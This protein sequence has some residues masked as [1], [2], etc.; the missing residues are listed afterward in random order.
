MDSHFTVQLSTFIFYFL[1]EILFFFFFQNHVRKSNNNFT[2]ELCPFALNSSKKN[3]WDETDK[4]L[5]LLFSGIILVLQ[6]FSPP[7]PFF[8]YLSITAC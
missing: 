4:S 1:Q 8:N 7:K 2:G 6:F 3:H 5:H